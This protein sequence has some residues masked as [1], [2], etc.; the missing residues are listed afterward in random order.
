MAKR[1]AILTCTVSLLFTTHIAFASPSTLDQVL[2]KG[3]LTCGIS[4]GLAGFSDADGKGQWQG[5][6]VDYC[7]AVAAAVLGDKNK[8]EFIPLTARER[9]Q[10]LQSG[11]VD[12]VSRNT[13]WTFE[14]DTTMGLN[15]VGVNFYDGQG[16]MVNKKSTI[17]QISQLHNQPICVQSETTTK[18]NLDDYFR[19]HNMSYQPVVFDTAIQIARAF[20]AGRCVA[21]TGD[22][23]GLYALRLNLAKPDSAI[24]LPEIISKEP[25][26]PVIREGDDRWLNITRW[27]LAAMINAEELG[28]TS[29]NVDQKRTSTNPEIR[30]LLGV[31]G[32][33]G[34]PLGLNSDWAY[35][36]IK[37][38]GNYDESFQ[39]N[40]GEDS[41]LAIPRGLNALWN[42]GGIMY[43]PPIR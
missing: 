17:T 38:V 21:I 18:L 2:T 23:S 14:R 43:A 10:A 13:T 11:L 1:L 22:Q 19:H 42:A 31:E 33:I 39:R 5:L 6:D 35:Q 41:P 36:V 25:L 8:V 15:F 28:I 40:V 34:Q 3:K 27:T 16:F 20:N 32:D 9:F 37:Q 12:V 26:G 4:T 29:A 24:I 7:R 30:R